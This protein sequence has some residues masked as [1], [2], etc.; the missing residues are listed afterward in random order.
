LKLRLSSP[1][2]SFGVKPS[3]YLG[4]ILSFVSTNLLAQ[5]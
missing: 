2:L 1:S 3:L 5:Q 4:K